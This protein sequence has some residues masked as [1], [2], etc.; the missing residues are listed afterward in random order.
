MQKPSESIETFE[1]YAGEPRATNIGASTRE[2]PVNSV[3]SHS[4][5]ESRAGE[6]SETLGRVETGRV[7]L[8]GKAP[9]FAA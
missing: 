8:M 9:D 4:E 3:S 6:K 5:G 1:L 7:P 2:V